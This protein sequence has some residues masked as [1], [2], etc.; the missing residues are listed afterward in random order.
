MPLHLFLFFDMLMFTLLLL[1]LVMLMLLLLLLILPQFLLLVIFLIGSFLPVFLL[2][3]V[4]PNRVMSVLRLPRL[5]SSTQQLTRPC[6]T[7]ILLV[8]LRFCHIGFH[9]MIWII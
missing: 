5:T 1:I 8:W 4:S 9:I 3:F 6:S 7:R 2:D